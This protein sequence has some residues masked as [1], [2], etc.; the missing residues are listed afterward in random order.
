MGLDRLW[1]RAAMEAG[2][3]SQQRVTDLTR[4]SNGD[5]AALAELTP[6]IYKELRHPAHRHMGAER[7][8]HTLQ[9]TA[10]VNAAYLRLADQ[11]NPRSQ[12]R[13]HFFAVSAHAMRRIL[14]SYAR[15]QP[16]QTR[17]RCGVVFIPELV[18]QSR[19]SRAHFTW[20]RCRCPIK[21]RSR[22]AVENVKVEYS[23]RRGRNGNR[24]R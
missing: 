17:W 16:S 14:V 19:S 20:K 23:W 3:V 18:A 1:K 9:T 5:D 2:S 11:S 12:N 13:A 10:L 4:W 8:G 21:V 24:S 7:P 22:S 6:L 15:S